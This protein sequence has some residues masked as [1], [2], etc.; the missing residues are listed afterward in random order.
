MSEEKLD[1]KIRLRNTF[2]FVKNS[3]YVNPHPPLNTRRRAGIRER[4]Q[5]S[6]SKGQ[7]VPW[8]I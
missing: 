5:G 3:D 4:D 7:R 1:Q 2:R 6:F 8:E